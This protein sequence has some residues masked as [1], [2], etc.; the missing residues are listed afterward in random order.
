MDHHIYENKNRLNLD[1]LVN[2]DS[3]SGPARKKSFSIP[4]SDPFAE[5]EPEEILRLREVASSL[6]G[7]LADIYE[8]LLV[9]YAGGKVKISMTDLAR[10]WGVSVTQICKNRE[11][12]IRIIREA[13]SR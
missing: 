2:D 7:R 5:N 11:K 9:Q 6:S 10:K 4:C 13:V 3:D 12:I 8:A 1:N